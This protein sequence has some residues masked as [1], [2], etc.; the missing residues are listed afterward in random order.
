MTAWMT[1]ENFVNDQLNEPEIVRG[2]Q[3]GQAD[4][5]EALCDQYSARLWRYVARLIGHDASIVADVFQETMLAVSESGKNLR[6]ETRLWAWLSAIAHNHVALFWRRHYREN[7]RAERRPVEGLIGNDD[8]TVAIEQAEQSEGVRK[9]LSEMVAQ[10]AVV[11]MAKYIDGLS[12]QQIVE[13]HGGTTE[14]VRS[15]LAR[16]RRDF[17]ERFQLSGDFDRTSSK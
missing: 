11:L 14:S 12:I 10:D 2:L 5:W 6:D 8:P 7:Q 9:L 15:R 17:K 1:T 13:L 4:A 16:A 3:N